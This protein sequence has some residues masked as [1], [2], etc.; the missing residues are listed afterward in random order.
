MK[1]NLIKF[2]NNVKEMINVANN[3]AIFTHISPDCDAI[4]SCMALQKG[5]T[6][7]G[8]NVTCFAKD[9]LTKNQLLIFD[10]PK[11]SKGDC[12]FS[13]FDLCISVDASSFGLLGDYAEGFK[14]HKNTI[15]FDHHQSNKM[16][17]TEH[18][19]SSGF[20]SCCEIVMHFLC[21]LKVEITK[22]MASMLYSGVSADT[23]SF[24]NS[25]VTYQ[26]FANA[27]KLVRLGANVNKVNELQYKN[28]TRIEV[29]CKKFLWTNLKFKND[30]A[31]CSV[32]FEDLKSMNAKKSDCDTFSNDLLGIDGVNYSFALIE[33]N[34][35]EIKLSMR[36][37]AGYDVQK[38]AFQL[39]GGGHICAS[40]AKI[41]NKTLSQAEEIVLSLIE[42]A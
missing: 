21:F 18:Y 26:T 4:G 12:D 33:E 1:N 22:D 14:N 40:G 19:V 5:L 2:S 42:K 16:F 34:K 39:G 35:G 29:L 36:S 41:Y 11:F 15:V 23:N 31:F 37:K 17:A 32:S 9:E 25:N 6:H 20:S 7:M 13:K 10:N 3:I 30:I 27:T 8:K 28:R 24:I 38:I